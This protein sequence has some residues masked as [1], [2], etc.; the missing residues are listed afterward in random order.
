MDSEGRWWAE[1]KKKEHKLSRRC[2]KYLS[3]AIPQKQ[4]IWVF[5]FE[6]N[7]GETGGTKKKRWELSKPNDDWK[8]ETVKPA[9]REAE[10]N[11]D[12][13]LYD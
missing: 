8:S 13:I 4:Q 6:R 9:E 7:K 12:K 3:E 11:G 10:G 5:S 2:Q 1:G